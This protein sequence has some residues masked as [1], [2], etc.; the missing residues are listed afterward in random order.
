MS[1]S[2]IYCLTRKDFLKA[3]W[4]RTRK[5]TSTLWAWS[6]CYSFTVPSTYVE[7][8]LIVYTSEGYKTIY[9]KLLSNAWDRLVNRNMRKYCYFLAQDFLEGVP[10]DSY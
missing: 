2:K 7:I 1:D 10:D 8:I 9:N 6:E 4:F 5:P 3:L